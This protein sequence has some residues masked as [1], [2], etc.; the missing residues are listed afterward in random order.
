MACKCGATPVGHCPFCRSTLVSKEVEYGPLKF[1][2]SSI[3]LL[4]GPPGAGKTTLGC[5]M[6]RA[7]SGY[8]L[9][10]EMAS[11]DAWNLR[12]IKTLPHT[13]NVLIDSLET[14]KIPKMLR[15]RQGITL[16]IAR[17]NAE[18]GLFGGL[19]DGYDADVVLSIN[20]E[21]KTVDLFKS[22]YQAD[23]I[24]FGYEID[25]PDIHIGEIA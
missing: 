3:V 20:K 14:I 12:T 8:V 25:W 10:N 5:N 17:L 23:G 24:S 19:A 2:T 6:L 13:G 22:R 11:Y 15:R 16:G 9:G 4:V 7:L 21:K 1:T 18:G